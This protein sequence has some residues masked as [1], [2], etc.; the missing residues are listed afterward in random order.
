MLCIIKNW[1]QRSMRF[2]KCY[3]T[4]STPNSHL[5][6][7]SE[8]F[9]YLLPVGLSPNIHWEME[10]LKI[11]NMKTSCL[12]PLRSQQETE[13][14]PQLK[15]SEKH[16]KK[17]RRRKQHSRLKTNE[18]VENESPCLVRG[19]TTGKGAAGPAA[20][21]R[22]TARQRTKRKQRRR[23]KKNLC[24]LSSLRDS[25][26]AARIQAQLEALSWKWGTEN[27]LASISQGGSRAKK[28]RAELEEKGECKTI[29]ASSWKTE[30]HHLSSADSTQA[31]S[32]FS[33]MS[34][35]SSIQRTHL[36]PV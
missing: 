23:K 21:Q 36:R 7:L 12:P 30:F 19:E 32:R 22:G 27:P 10:I 16:P 35:A 8:M 3:T 18:Q 20:L 25:A 1:I 15:Q 9:Y 5:S 31:G 14:I 29:S 28:G 17:R 4:V 24:C 26:W 34:Y 11:S 33:P 2:S 13:F 6:F